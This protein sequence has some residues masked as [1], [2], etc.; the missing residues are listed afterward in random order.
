M[1]Y[2]DQF[3]DLTTAEAIE[4]IRLDGLRRLSRLIDPD[5]PIRKQDLVPFLTKKLAREDIVRGIYE[6]PSE[7]NQAAVQEA[8]IRPM[9]RL[10]VGRFEAKYGQ[11]P[12][13]GTERAP[14]PLGLLMPGGAAIP[15]D[16]RPILSRF[17]PEPRPL[18]IASEE[19]LTMSHTSD[20][21]CQP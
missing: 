21:R 13:R 10:D 19:E 17:L 12:A 18:T 6:S 7:L 16:L 5:A 15:K 11:R 8:L 2:R 20:N 3:V 14:D 9:G 1:A 4:Q